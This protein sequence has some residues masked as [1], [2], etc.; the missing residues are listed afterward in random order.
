M[1]F[2][3]VSVLTSIA[4]LHHSAHVYKP[5]MQPTGVDPGFYMSD[6]HQLN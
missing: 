6:L 4:K 5:Y 3:D 1:R 2:F